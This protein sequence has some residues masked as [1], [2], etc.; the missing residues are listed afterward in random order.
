VTELAEALP[1]HDRAAGLIDRHRRR[2]GVGP[3][4]REIDSPAER[5]AVARRSLNDPVT[6]SVD[7]LPDRDRVAARID[8]Q[9]RLA[10]VG[11]RQR[12]IHL[13]R[14]CATRPHQQARSAHQK[15]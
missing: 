2:V 11:A 8:C 9:L 5:P 6:V 10:G 3:G 13:R 4:Q 1:H 14:P 7:A 15:R 12:Q